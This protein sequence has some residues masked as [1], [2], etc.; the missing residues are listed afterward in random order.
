MFKTHCSFKLSSWQ[1]VFEMSCLLH[2]VFIFFTQ[3]YRD[4]KKLEV[5]HDEIC[6]NL[7][8]KRM[9]VLFFAVDRSYAYSGWEGAKIVGDVMDR[10]YE[11]T[12]FQEGL[13][14][15]FLLSLSKLQLCF[16]KQSLKTQKK[17]RIRNYVSNC[18]LYLFFLIQ[19]NLLIFGE[20]NAD[21]SRP[22]EVCYDI[23]FPA[24]V[25]SSEKA[26]PEQVKYC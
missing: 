19:K 13:E 10:N 17:L 21:V 7:L 23:Y 6:F 3:K 25:S 4:I 20:E 1:F 26:H 5:F 11:I 18:N 22:R 16:I 24:S 9:L 8:I 12:L 15:P 14:Q 2:L